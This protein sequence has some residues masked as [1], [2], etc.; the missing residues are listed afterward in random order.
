MA[1]RVLVA[2]VVVVFGATLGGSRALAEDPSTADVMSVHAREC[3][4]TIST[5]AA[6]IDRVGLWSNIF[7]I[8]GAFVAG[9]G[10]VL[11]ALLSTAG[12]RKAAAVAG[13]LGAIL[14]VL[15]KALPDRADIYA[16]IP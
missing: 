4:A 8:T 16:G 10:S 14:S 13:A 3:D 1:R 2:L 11:A 6:R 5:L 15:P 12:K 7:M 9:T